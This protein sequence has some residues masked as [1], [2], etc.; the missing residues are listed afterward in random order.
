MNGKVY[1]YTRV[2]FSGGVHSDSPLFKCVDPKKLEALVET[3]K[4]KVLSP[5]SQGE[6]D[7]FE[8]FRQ[9]WKSVGLPE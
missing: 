8:R 4:D 2:A 9:T 1:G 7:A 5:I 3:H 6:R